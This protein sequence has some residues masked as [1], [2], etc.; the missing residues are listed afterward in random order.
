MNDGICQCGCGM[1]TGVV[2]QTHRKRGLVKG[3]HYRFIQ[4]HNGHGLDN[5]RW[6]GGRIKQDRYWSIYCPGHPRA[7]NNHV[8]EHIIL[9]EKALGKPL[10]QNANMHHFDENPLNNDN[11][12]I[13]CQDSNYHKALHQ[14]RRSYLNCGH[15][16]WRKC[17]YCKEYDDP[18]NLFVGPTIYHKVCKNKYNKLHRVSQKEG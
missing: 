12:L 10:P 15:A 6:K 8:Y 17:H 4:G 18:V 9:G 14:R 11:N 2:P 7:I 16:Y 3:E 13:I 5:S 1:T